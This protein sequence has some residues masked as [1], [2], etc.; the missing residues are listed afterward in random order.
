MSWAWASLTT[1]HR[2]SVISGEMQT[3]VILPVA[4]CPFCISTKYYRLEARKA[5][6]LPLRPQLLHCGIYSD[7]R[8][9]LAQTMRK[10]RAS[11][12]ARVK[13]AMNGDS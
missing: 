6:S 12:I 4:I 7:M 11:S 10:V 8:L 3:R 13:V 1:R 2:E 5:C 9:I